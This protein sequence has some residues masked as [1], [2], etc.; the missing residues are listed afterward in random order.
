MLSEA[1][2]GNIKIL[3]FDKFS[4]EGITP[5]II[6]GFLNGRTDAIKVAKA[7][8]GRLGR[9]K[10]MR[11]LPGV[12]LKSIG[13]FAPVRSTIGRLGIAN[14]PGFLSMMRFLDIITLRAPGERNL[15]VAEDVATRLDKSYRD[16]VDSYGVHEHRPG[17]N[18]T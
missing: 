4:T 14:W 18:H 10:N 7:N 13:R 8:T 6:A 11:S 9:C 1:G 2:F 15:Q 5:S 17:A 12:S 3:E 16:A